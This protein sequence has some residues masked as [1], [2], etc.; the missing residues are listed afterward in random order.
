MVLTGGASRRMGRDKMMI[1]VAGVPCAGVV[2]AAAKAV[3][4]PCVEVGPG[5]TGLA[6]V[7]EGEPGRGPLAAIAA[8]W[9][10]LQKG[11]HRGPVLVLAGDLPLVRPEL[12]DWLA[13]QAGDGSVVPVVGERRQ[14]LLARWSAAALDAAVQAVT[15]GVAPVG[16]HPLLAREVQP[17]EWGEVV[18]GDS[19]CDMDTPADVSRLL[20]QAATPGPQRTPE[21]FNMDAPQWLA[22]FADGLALSPP[23][24][25]EAS[26]LLELASVA[27][28]SSERWA[29]PLSCWLAGRSG[30]PLEELVGLAREVAD[31]GAG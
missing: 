5:Y 12:R 2:A 29:A 24:E 13:V 14:P 7:V 22:L 30:R 16:G 25:E 9:E 20:G 8:G 4:D 1:P 27:A 17:G 23:T 11:G 3:A 28:H 31:G 18:G 10:A 26:A 21:R 6:R 15:D 19:F